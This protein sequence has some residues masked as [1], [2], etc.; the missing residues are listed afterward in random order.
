MEMLEK[1]REDQLSS[2]FIKQKKRKSQRIRSV[3]NEKEEEK[4]EK[5]EILRDFVFVEA[6]ALRLS[7][8]ESIYP[9]LYHS[10]KNS[11]IPIGSLSSSSSM[12]G[13]LSSRD[14]NISAK[15]ALAH[16]TTF[17]GSEIY[18]KQSNTSFS[19]SSIS[20]VSTTTTKK[21][22]RG[23]LS[24]SLTIVENGRIKGFRDDIPMIILLLDELD[25]MVF[26]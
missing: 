25:Y 4:K 22:K 2:Q 11:G 9:L 26:L 12:N 7:S 1:T 20:N 21:R 14:Q 13:Y 15:R 8:P 16:L 5:V 23:N 18:L 3:D 24:D 17:F 10:I 6:N 19:S